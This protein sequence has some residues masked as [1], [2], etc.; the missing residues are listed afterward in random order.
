MATRRR[1]G[2]FTGEDEGDDDGG[3]LPEPGMDGEDPSGKIEVK[4][5][6]QFTPPDDSLIGVLDPEES[7]EFGN[8][9][10]AR[11]MQRGDALPRGMTV[12]GEQGYGDAFGGNTPMMPQEPSPVAARP[13]QPTSTRRVSSPGSMSALFGSEGRDTPMFGNMG[14]LT[15]G[16][17][18]VQSSQGRPTPTEMM[19]S[20]LRMFRGGA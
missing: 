9:T 16:G 4:L 8:Y 6:G 18:G 17:L 2:G 3:I 5:P 10:T 7:G 1:L 20:L 12:Q 11:E 15:E 13:A 19:L 14:G